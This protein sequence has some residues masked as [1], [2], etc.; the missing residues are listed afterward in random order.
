MAILH[1]SWITREN[2]GYLFI[3]GETW[4][5][6]ASVEAPSANGVSSHPLAMTQTELITF[7]G[8]H[9]LSIDKFF[10]VSAS[11]GSRQSPESNQHHW[12][13]QILALPTQTSPL[14]DEPY[15]VLSVKSPVQDTDT[16]ALKLQLWEVE[17]FCLTS[18][19]ASKF[20]Q[21][22]PLGSFNSDTY[23]GGDLRFW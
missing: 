3:W 8:S 15:P 23:V 16:P 6:K 1:G 20:L 9:S 14:S 18:L 19:E 5:T 12:Q 2:G 10:E 4:R 11:S 7:L 21:A 22:L 13:A 17:G